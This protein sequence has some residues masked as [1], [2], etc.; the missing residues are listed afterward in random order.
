MKLT[1]FE[2]NPILS[3]NP[4]S[5]WE[6]LAACNPAAWYEDGTFYMLYRAAGHDA[7]HRI[8][9]G[10]AESRDGFRFR[11]VMDRPVLSP[12]DNGFDAGSVEDPR[13]VKFGDE[14]YMTYAFR[15]YPP[16]QYWKYD[17]DAVVAP[18]HNDYTPKCLRENVGNTALA[19]STDLR[20]FKKVGRLTD[21]SLDDRDVILFPER[22]GGKFYM[23][24]RP[25]EY[26]GPEY[27]TDAP[28]VWLKCSDDLM[29][30]NVPSR[31]LLKGREPWE[32][33]VGGNAPPLRTREGWLMLYHGVDEHHTYRI[34]ACILA[35]DDPSQ[36]LYRTR[37]FILEPELEFEKNGLYRWGVV[38]PTGNVIVDD[39]LYVYY[40]A[41]DQYCCV[42]TANVDE[43]LQ[44]IKSNS[45]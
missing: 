33:K 4:V 1:K 36:V 20:T 28:S 7:Q 42:A 2:G 22:I 19:V 45:R 12:G 29:T 18:R 44:F 30:W 35:I 15:P 25:K 38:F 43:L 10:L 40:G 31:L 24:H 23:L 5:E 32:R 6:S 21:P 39:T 11:R 14:Y 8:H 3:P 26:V 27:G 9:I 37:D 16:G 34:G 41:A 17:Y 13:L